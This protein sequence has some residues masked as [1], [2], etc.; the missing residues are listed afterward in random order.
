MKYSYI[1]GKSIQPPCFV[2]D[3]EGVEKMKNCVLFKEDWL[4]G[5]QIVQ[6]VSLWTDRW[7][8]RKKGVLASVG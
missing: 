7:S 5:E 4:G 8:S 3:Y 1:Y 2:N 6:R